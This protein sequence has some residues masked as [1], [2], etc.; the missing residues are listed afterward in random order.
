MQL[1]VEHVA[2]QAQDPVAVADWYVKH[3]GFRIVRRNDDPAKTHFIADASGKC[4][5]EIYNNPAASVLDYRNMHFLQL[6]LAFQAAD[7]TA[8]RDQLLEAGCT[9]AEDLRTTP[10]G[11]TLCMLRDPFGFA[12]QLCR[13]AKPMV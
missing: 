5:V 4:L 1:S 8:T 2:W 13:R 3:L 9:I 6:H 10:A 12:I 7:P 11:D